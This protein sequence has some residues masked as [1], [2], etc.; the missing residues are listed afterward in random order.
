MAASPLSSI[1]R[2]NQLL[3]HF[4]VNK[5]ILIA[6]VGAGVTMSQMLNSI[7]TVIICC[8]LQRSHN[9]DHSLSLIALWI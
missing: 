7:L 8:T 6:D 5:T 4:D 3:L 1:S 2:S 9:C